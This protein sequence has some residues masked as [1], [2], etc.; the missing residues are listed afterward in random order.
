MFKDTTELAPFLNKTTAAGVAKL[1]KDPA[2]QQAY[3]LRA[4]FQLPGS[5]NHL[6]DHAERLLAPDV[7]VDDYDI[8]HSRRQTRGIVEIEFEIDATYFRI[9]D[10]GGQRSERKKWYDLG[11]GEEKKRGEI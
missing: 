4:D 10:V 3:D 11:I 6:L 2:I 7:V 1:W 8:L 5:V 9:V